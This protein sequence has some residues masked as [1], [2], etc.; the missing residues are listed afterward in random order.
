MIV[1]DR[2]C[3]TLSN[4]KKGRQ[5]GYLGNPLN[6]AHTGQHPR[7]MAKFPV[8]AESSRFTG[9]SAPVHQYR[10]EEIIV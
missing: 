6:S 4:A 3:D 7:N 5:A 8:K 9:Q 2:R 1:Y 10:R